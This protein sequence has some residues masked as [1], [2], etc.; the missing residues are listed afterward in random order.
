MNQKNKYIFKKVNEPVLISDIGSYSTD[1]ILNN[2][3][4]NM[5]V[6]I[7]SQY[8]SKYGSAYFAIVCAYHYG[9]RFQ[10]DRIGHGIHYVYHDFTDSSTRNRSDRLRKE[11]EYLMSFASYLIFSCN[12]TDFILE[13]DYNEDENAFSNQFVQ[14]AINYANSIGVEDILTKPYTIA[15]KAADSVVRS[16]FRGRSKVQTLKNKLEK[17][18]SS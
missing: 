6:G 2:N 11:T 12:F 14:F 7:D 10:G 1:Q 17:S 16:S 9:S 15:C 8:Y 18:K 4:C 13:V 3:D 5:Y